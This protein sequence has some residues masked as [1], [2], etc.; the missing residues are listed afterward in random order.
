MFED[1]V[2]SKVK[3]N[4]GPVRG[5]AVGMLHGIVIAA[6]IRV[7]ARAPE[8]AVS[9]PL[10]ISVAFVPPVTAVQPVAPSDPVAPLDPSETFTLPPAPVDPVS[11]PPVTPGPPIDPATLRRILS[12]GNPGPTPAGRDS[13]TVG[14]VLDAAMVDEPAVV[15]HQPSPRY[16]PVLQQAGLDGRVTVEFIIDTTGHLEA[17][18]FRIL[19]SSN[20]GF[21][22]AAE[23]TVRHSVFR[24]ARVHGHP[25]R[26]RT[27]QSLAFR[28][29]QS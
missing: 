23:E 16:P 26:Q 29:V 28:I 11:I 7:T 17:P 15:I 4:A 21:N 25:V 27:I 10:M 5:L 13:V 19:E 24:P 12:T 6:A 1:L 3:R 9:P 14:S 8:P 20:A 2:S 22:A 18:S